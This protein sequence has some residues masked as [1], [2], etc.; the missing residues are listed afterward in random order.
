MVLLLAVAVG[1]STLATDPGRPQPFLPPQP[2][3]AFSGTGLLTT[4]RDR[5]FALVLP[6]AD[7][8]RFFGA[9]PDARRSFPQEVLCPGGGLSCAEV[10]T[11]LYLSPV[12]LR[13]AV[14]FRAW[15]K[16]TLGL[17]PRT[18]DRQTGPRPGDGRTP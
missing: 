2:Q 13:D 3:D 4:S 6:A 15:L 16:Q 9:S 5:L 8:D 10:T 17:E 11:G 12:E 7:V 18:D 14:F 1:A